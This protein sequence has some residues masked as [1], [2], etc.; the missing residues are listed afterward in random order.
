MHEWL[1]KMVNH[2]ID[3]SYVHIYIGCLSKVAVYLYSAN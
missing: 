1:Y 2:A 3:A